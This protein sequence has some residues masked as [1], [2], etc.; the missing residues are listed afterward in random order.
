MCFCCCC[1]NHV[2][3]KMLHVL[4]YVISVQGMIALLNHTLF[5]L[6]SLCAATR[7]VSHWPQQWGLAESLTL[8]EPVMNHSWFSQQ[9]R[10]RRRCCGCGT[11]HGHWKKVNCVSSDVLTM[12]SP[13]DCCIKVFQFNGCTVL[14]NITKIKSQI[15]QD[16]PQLILI[17]ED[18][19]D[20]SFGWKIPNYHWIH[21]SCTIQHSTKRIWGGGVSILICK[22]PHISFECLHFPL[23]EELNMSDIVVVRLYSHNQTGITFIDR[24]C[25]H[26]SPAQYILRISR[27]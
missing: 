1:F 2:L 7:L 20:D 9:N 19:L 4:W 5:V 26:I 6:S 15:L 13:S 17:Q 10:L 21:C 11:N 3:T 27:S 25:Q 8:D 14:S 22:D 12:T 16:N 23:T 24:Y 18:W